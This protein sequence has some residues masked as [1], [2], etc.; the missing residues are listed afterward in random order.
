MQAL[1]VRSHGG[2]TYNQTA[3]RPGAQHE[4]PRLVVYIAQSQITVELLPI[5]CLLC[6]QPKC[7]VLLLLKAYFVPLKW[8]VACK[9][10]KPINRCIQNKW[11]GST[12]ARPIP[13]DVNFH[14]LYFRAVDYTRLSLPALHSVHHGKAATCTCRQRESSGLDYYR[15]IANYMISTLLSGK[16]Q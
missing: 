15:K 8:Y 13:V 9:V 10:L 1:A 12:C 3:A 6:S 14:R 11:R 5:H 4:D 7:S 2:H 16:L